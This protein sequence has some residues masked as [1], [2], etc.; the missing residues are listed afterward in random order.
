MSVHKTHKSR[1]SLAQKDSLY[2]YIFVLPWIIGFTFLFLRP[3]ITSLRMTFSVVTVSAEGFNM[4]F[5]GLDNYIAALTQNPDYVRSVTDSILA[6][7]Y[8]VPVITFFSL[9]IAVIINQ[10]FHGRYLARALFFLPVIIA[11]GSVI[12]VI[13]NTMSLQQLSGSDSGNIY[14]GA[15]MAKILLNSGLPEALVT[16]VTDVISKIFDLTWKCGIQILLYLSGLQGIGETYYEA[17]S[18]E[19]ATGWEKFWKITFPVISPITLVVIFYT[20][21]DS[22]I[23]FSN[24]V[25]KII[26]W[27]QINLFYEKSTTMAFIYFFI[28]FII[29]GLIIFIVSKRVNYRD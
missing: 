2:G 1:L 5:A 3:V 11:T 12:D 25:M 9:F 16:T 24:Y 22:F 28:I 7:L 26:Y 6:M 21:V 14:N 19:G 20:V 23:D 8:Q 17:A 10:K 15:Q 4:K 13:R 18:V 27:D 29:T